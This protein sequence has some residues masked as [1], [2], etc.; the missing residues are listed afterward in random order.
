M[1][2]LHIFFAPKGRNYG[3][4]N[5]LTTNSH[6]ICVW[7]GNELFCHQLLLLVV[8]VIYVVEV[9]E[10]FSLEI[11]SSKL[12]YVFIQLNAT[13]KVVIVD[14]VGLMLSNVNLAIQ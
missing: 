12:I 6:I 8:H 3:G 2:H 13:S 1:H 4:V 7:S 9:K 11:L 10:D 14:V 5:L